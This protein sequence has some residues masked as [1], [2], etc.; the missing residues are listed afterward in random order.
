MISAISAGRRHMAIGLLVTGAALAGC[1]TDINTASSFYQPGVAG[2]RPVNIAGV[3][4]AGTVSD[5]TIGN[6]GGAYVLTNS[7][8]VAQGY[9]GLLAHTD[10][11]AD[12]APGTAVYVADYEVAS[13][14][15]I[16]R[17]ELDRLGGFSA[18]DA[19]QIFLTANTV[20]GRVTGADGALR[21]DAALSN[22]SFE[23]D[24]SY[25]GTEGDIR[26][27]VGARG[28][29]GAFHGNSGDI[30]YAGALAGSR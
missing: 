9:A 26:G 20:T 28:I 1:G 27:L 23:G 8:G 21:V 10:V 19:G 15:N 11:G 12:P 14:S 30:V 17:I 25:G 6:G 4:E 16:T 13:L 7:G 24:V 29:A 2:S 22:G 3:I 5:A 18:T